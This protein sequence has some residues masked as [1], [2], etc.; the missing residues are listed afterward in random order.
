MKNRQALYGVSIAVMLFWTAIIGCILAWNWYT[1]FRHAEELAKNEAR[2]HFNKDLSFRKWATRHGGVYVPIDARTPPNPGL[3]HIPERDIETPSGKKL[4]LMNPAYILRQTMSEYAEL[5]GVKG[6]ITSLK[7]INPN[8]APDTWEDVAL[9]QFAQG[10]TEI[11]EFTQVDGKP[12]LRLMRPLTTEAGCL[13]CHAFQGYK[14]GDVRGGVAV[15]VPMQAYLEDARKEYLKDVMPLVL[16]WMLGL[17]TLAILFHEV[18]KRMLEQQR[19]EAELQQKNWAISRSNADLTRF[20]EVSAHHLM[21]PTRRL[22]SYAQRLRSRLLNQPGLSEDEEAR[23][24]LETLEHDAGHLRSLVR[25]IQLYLAAGVPRGEVQLEDANAAVSVVE[26]RLADQI[27]AGGARLEIQTLPQ[28]WLDRPRLTDLFAVL[29]ENALHHGRPID[30]KLAQVIRIEGERIDG[31]CRYSVS[32]N[33]PGIGSEYLERVF[34]IFER[35]APASIRVDDDS[36]TGIG[37]SIARR[38]I[39]SRHGKIWIENPAQG[40]ARVVFELPDGENS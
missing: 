22:T 15:T 10:L 23:H 37:L 19:A 34:E 30:P 32:D 40:G 35:L 4:T 8:N 1:A 27:K 7:L 26:K 5:F 29:L 17:V 18:R 38:I 31:V 12:V 11:T 24:A 20:A 28:A 3:A 33:G 2:I 36:G 25:D 13:K 21:E 9:Q 39:E 16:I 6:K 14:V